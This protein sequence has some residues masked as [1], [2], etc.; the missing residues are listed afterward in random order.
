M[1]TNL[2]KINKLEQHNEQKIQILEVF[3]FYENCLWEKISRRVSP[4][5]ENV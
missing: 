4:G 5:A 2:V 1:Y 3:E